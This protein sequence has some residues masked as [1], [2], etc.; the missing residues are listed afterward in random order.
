MELEPGDQI[1]ICAVKGNAT[2]LSVAEASGLVREYEGEKYHFC[3]PRCA[4]LFDADPHS[5]V[6]A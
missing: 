3:C 1:V 5:Y 2:A 6:A 4:E